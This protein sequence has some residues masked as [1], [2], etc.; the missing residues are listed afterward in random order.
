MFTAK[1][2]QKTPKSGLYSHASHRPPP[3]IL[4][5]P[6]P[7]KLF[8]SKPPT[9]KLPQLAKCFELGIFWL[10][11]QYVA[12]FTNP[13]LLSHCSWPP[14]PMPP[15]GIPATSSSLFSDNTLPLRECIQS[16]FIYHLY[17]NDS[18]NYIPSPDFSKFHNY[19]D[20]CLLHICTLY[21]KC[22]IYNMTPLISKFERINNCDSDFLTPWVN[23]HPHGA[24]QTQIPVVLGSGPPFVPKHSIHKYSV[25]NSGS[26]TY[27]KPA[28]FP[29]AS[30]LPPQCKIPNQPH[31][32]PG[33]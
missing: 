22:S 13:S 33:L 21:L 31:F 26:K 18:W 14:L 2:V 8:L 19:V 12:P 11:N 3:S 24:V 4:P 5:P 1:F 28:H 7:L 15:P 23:N 29:P 20:K 16:G 6:T 9:S 32:L 30:L 17:S 27:T 25:V 10:C